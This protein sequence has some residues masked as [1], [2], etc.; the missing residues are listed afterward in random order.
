[1]VCSAIAAAMWLTT[2]AATV[3]KLL[4]YL[5]ICFH[6]LIR[7]ADQTVH[8]NIYKH[9][10]VTTKKAYTEFIKEETLLWNSLV[11][12]FMLL[13]RVFKEYAGRFWDVLGTRNYMHACFNFVN[14]M[15][16]NFPR[17]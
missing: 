8:R 12:G 11:D 15:L 16:S 14:S 3:S 2:A 13:P 10:C 4:L 9:I 1:M 17:H 6:C 7:L 5:Y